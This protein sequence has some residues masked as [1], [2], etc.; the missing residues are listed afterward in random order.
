MNSLRLRTERLDLIAATAASARAAADGDHA[1]FGKLLGAVVPPEWPQELM[2]DAQVRMAEALEWGAPPD[3]FSCWY[4]VLR[5][6]GRVI[7]TAGFK[8]GP[9]SGRVDI[10]YGLLEAYHR[11]GLGPEAVRALVDW[12]FRDARVERI[13]AETLPQLRPSIR[14]MEKLGFEFVGA[15]AT[16]HGGEENVVQYELT[17]ERWTSALVAPAV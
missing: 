8:G 15:V 9:V 10:G 14:V 2:A 4:V 1:L 5:D 6:E 3:G 12:A 13:V 11:R 16:G 17:R 7:G